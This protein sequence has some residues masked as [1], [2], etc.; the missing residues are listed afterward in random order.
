MKV[1]RTRTLVQTAA[2]VALCSLP[3]TAHPRVAQNPHLGLK[4]FSTPSHQ[5]FAEANPL[6]APG[7]AE[8]L[9]H[10]G[11][12]SRC[13]GAEL[14]DE[15][16]MDYFLARYYSSTLGRFTRPDPLIPMIEASSKAALFSFA[17][18]P[19]Q[20]NKYQYALNN[21]LNVVD[22]NGRQAVNPDGTNASFNVKFGNYTARVD[23]NPHDNPNA[24]VKRGGKNIGRLSIRPGGKIWFQSVRGETIPNRIGIAIKKA[25]R[26]QR[27]KLARGSALLSLSIGVV[28]A[29]GDIREEL[30]TGFVFEGEAAKL[31]NL[32]TAAE[33]LGEGQT[34]Q[35]VDPNDP[36][37]RKVHK[38]K[39]VKGEFVNTDSS[40]CFQITQ[41]DEGNIDVVCSQ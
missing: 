26:A 20:W 19:R 24:H 36:L 22:P 29:L 2:L 37:G 35:I 12:R 16:G 6:I 17:A 7:L 18:D 28:P 41:N 4:T 27:Q 13:S 34:I 32:E 31:A 14:D 5:G 30:E 40:S 9:C 15:T 21:P 1:S 23:M 25:V 33:F 11:V 10:Q 38:F 3:L 8:S 39:V